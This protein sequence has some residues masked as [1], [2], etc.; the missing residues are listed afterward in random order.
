MKNKL[1]LLILLA[2]ALRV[3]AQLADSTYTV[4]NI[5]QSYQI[6]IGFTNVLDTYLSGEK[7]NG[8]GFTFLS[9]REFQ[10]PDARWSTIV[11]HQAHI[12]RGDDRAENES[13]LEASYNLYLGRYRSWQLFGNSLLLQA[14]AVANFNAG[15]I[16]YIRSIGNNPAQAR[17]ALN[18][19]P[20][21]IATYQF[22][23]AKK[24]LSLRYEAEL[25]LFGL[26]FSPNYGQSYYEIFSQGN[27]DHNIVPTTFVSA[28]TFRQQF[29]VRWQTSATTTLS[30][31]Y[32][33]DIQQSHV[34]NLKQHVWS[35]RFMIG[36]ITSFAK[37]TKK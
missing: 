11:Q 6:G 31:G 16:Y 5:T 2:L 28:P 27:Y 37:V 26:M 15:L 9:L 20:S 14:G 23:F 21:A 18:I 10:K 33:G 7:F 19:M 17:I 4:R 29:S 35:N 1:S 22:P 12:S 3:N 30:I 36:I 24:R 13:T 8:L 34:N 25:P 32:M